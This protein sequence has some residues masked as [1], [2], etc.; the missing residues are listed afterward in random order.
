MELGTLLDNGNSF[1]DMDA[2]RKLHAR[3]SQ[4]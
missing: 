1:S 2:A 4:H 3:L